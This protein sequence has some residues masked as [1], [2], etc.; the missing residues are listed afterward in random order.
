MTNTFFI[1]LFLGALAAG[2]GLDAQQCSTRTTIGRYVVVCNGYLAP[3]ANAPM[4]PA[5]LLATASAD[6]NGAFT[7]TGIVTLGGGAIPQTV[8]GTEKINRDCTGTITYSQTLGGQPGP[9]LNITFVVSGNG[10]RIDGLVTDAGAV[11]SCELRRM[12][13]VLSGAA[14]PAER[15]RLASRAADQKEVLA[16]TR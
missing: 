3:A 2:Q 6:E 11:L 7:G 4:T 16:S 14:S 5:K 9:P 13:P 15:P 8:T 12:T 10:E 1:T